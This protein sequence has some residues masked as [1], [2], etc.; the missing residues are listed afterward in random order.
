[1]ATRFIFRDIVGEDRGFNTSGDVLTKTVDGFDLR[2]LWNEFQQAMAIFNA[3]YQPIIAGLTFGT[4]NAG[5]VLSLDGKGMEFERASEFGLS[6]AQR[7]VPNNFTAGYPLEWWDLRTAFTRAFLRDAT[8][9]Q[10]RAQTDGAFV[11][12][13][14]LVYRLAMDALLYPK[15]A[16]SRDANA[17]G[18]Q[19]YSLYAGGSDDIPPIYAGRT[20][21]SAHNHYIASGASTVDGQDLELL[22]ES[23]TEHGI[24]I[25]AGEQLVIVVHPAEGKVIR[26]FRAGQG[27]VP[28]PYD[29][30]PSAAAPAYLSNEFVVGKTPE[31]T[32]QGLE[33]IGSFGRALIV[34]S[35]FIPEHYVVA[36]STSG[37]NNSNNVLAVRSHVNP[38]YKGIVLWPGSSNYPL[39]E[40]NYSYGVGFGVRNRGAGA[41]MQITANSTYTAPA[42]LPV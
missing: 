18:I 34:E 1:M 33:I 42:T 20:F 38:A 2:E 6:Q 23:I 17:E 19:V 10:V 28:S 30:I 36:Y 13:D 5:D 35:Y 32:F 31:T 22:I 25:S 15:A 39:V 9:E 37:P 29:F 7:A 12:G 14:K 3:G 26:G 11:A 41:V 21:A 16:G 8:A 40:S 4:I 24:G 27:T